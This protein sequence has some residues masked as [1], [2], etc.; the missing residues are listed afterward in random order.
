MGT[1]TTI[2]KEIKEQILAR[3]KNDGIS[4]MKAAEEHGI[5]SKTIYYWLRKGSV[6]TTSILETGRLRKQNKDLLD[7]VG[8]LTYEVSKLKKNKSGF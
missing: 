7:L 6:Q 8:L 1:R 3:I 4:V 2:P 5:S